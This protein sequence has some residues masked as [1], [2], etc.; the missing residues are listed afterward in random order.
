MELRDLSARSL[1]D[2]IQLVAALAAIS[3]PPRGLP[4]PPIAHIP[5]S[6]APLAFWARVPFYWQAMFALS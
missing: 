4:T 3:Q 6:P 2:H 5:I 1:T